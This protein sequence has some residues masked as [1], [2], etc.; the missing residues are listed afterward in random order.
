MTP[1]IRLSAKHARALLDLVDHL[2]GN[3]PGGFI[4][5]CDMEDAEQSIRD[6]LAPRPTSTAVKKTRAK[7]A[8]KTKETKRI[9][10]LVAE[11]ADGRC[12]ACAAYFA[13]FNPAQMDHFWGR[14][15][16]AQSVENCWLLHA[17]CHSDKTANR[18]S[19]EHWLD[20]FASHCAR[21]AYAR[22][23]TRA[24]DSIGVRAMARGSE[25]AN[26]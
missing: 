2:S 13:E 4:Y 21:H 16:T 17:T 22:E 18:P 10:A 25:V 11:R 1:S 9:R 19:R 12:E 3:K 15:K 26:G 5:S 8:S 14:G 24:R 23:M 7:R 20:M 6:Q